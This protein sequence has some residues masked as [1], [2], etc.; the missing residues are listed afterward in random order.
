MISNPLQIKKYYASNATSIRMPWMTVAPVVAIG[1]L[2]A[3]YSAI[4]ILI[5]FHGA[6]VDVDVQR[7]HL[8]C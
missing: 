6:G 2:G 8:E 1:R 5:T 4:A 7:R 3:I